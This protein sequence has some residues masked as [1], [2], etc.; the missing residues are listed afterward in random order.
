MVAESILQVAF[1]FSPFMVYALG[2]CTRCNDSNGEEPDGFLPYLYGS[3]Q[4]DRNSNFR[5][6]SVTLKF[7]FSC[8]LFCLF[9]LLK[10]G[11]V[12]IQ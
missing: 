4:K 10:C 3:A 8:V 1:F 2:L 12:Y 7:N 6:S 11:I 5:A 9:I